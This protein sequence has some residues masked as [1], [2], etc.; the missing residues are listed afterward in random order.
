MNKKEFRTLDEQVDI[1]KGK[2]LI[3]NDPEKVKEILLRENYF[4]V[5]GYRQMFYNSNRKFIHG[6]TFEELYSTF[7]FDRNLRNLLFKNLLV[8]EN[9]IKSIISYQ[10]SKKYGYKEQD[11]LNPK[12]FTRDMK[13]ARRVDDVLSKMKRQIRING[14]KHTATFHYMSKY[15]YVPLWIL[16]KVLSFGLINELFGILKE[17]DK[18]EIA[19]IYGLDKETLKIYIQLLSNYR[20][21]CAHEDIVFDHKTQ[22]YIDDTKYHSA[23]KLKQNSL[24]EYTQ[25]KTDLF[26]VVIIFKQMLQPDRFKEFMKEL[27]MVFDVFDS[28]VDTIT[29]EVLFNRMGF[30]KNYMDIIDM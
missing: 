27:Q 30:P 15:K 11:Y 4:F 19:D 23:L 2:G 10:L 24:G 29:N 12:N 6:T 5:N 20:N 21:L 26:A 3:I 14:E 17:E 1:L 18:Q 7:L 8:I 13:E 16:V 28:N 25:G 9:N 22:V